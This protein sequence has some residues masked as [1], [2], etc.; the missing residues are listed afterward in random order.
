MRSFSAD[1]QTD[2]F[3]N[4][5]DSN[6]SEVTNSN[7]KI[8]QITLIQVLCEELAVT[9]WPLWQV[10]RNS[11]YWYTDNTRLTICGFPQKA[12]STFSAN[13]NCA[14]YTKTK[15]LTKPHFSVTFVTTGWLQFSII[16]IQYL[17]I[18]FHS[19]RYLQP[20]HAIYNLFP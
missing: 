15:R 7:Y 19:Y 17:L 18:W 20:L 6:F 5:T 1:K 3:S 4:L 11:W 14:I 10:F 13:T 12:I 16:Y 9:L 2:T 8:E